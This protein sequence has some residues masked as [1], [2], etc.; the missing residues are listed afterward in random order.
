MMTD[1]HINQAVFLDGNPRQ[2]GSLPGVRATGCNLVECAVVSAVGIMVPL[3]K[4]TEHKSIISQTVAR[5]EKAFERL[6]KALHS[7]KLEKFLRGKVA[8]S[9]FDVRD[10]TLKDAPKAS[11]A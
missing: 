3:E 11:Q 2:S 9:D 5:S 4:S 1:P 6:S 10:L 7:A 8:V